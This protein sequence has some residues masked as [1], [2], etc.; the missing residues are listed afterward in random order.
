M[1]DRGGPLSGSTFDALQASAAMNSNMQGFHLLKNM[2]YF[3]V[4]VLKGICHMCFSRGLYIVEEGKHG[5]LPR[6]ASLE[7]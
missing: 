4:L 7:V 2:W 1:E 6:E 5:D 3:P